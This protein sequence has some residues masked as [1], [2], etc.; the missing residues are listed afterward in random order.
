MTAPP[1]P[2]PL[3]LPS[4]F[5]RFRPGFFVTSPLGHAAARRAF[6]TTRGGWKIS[7]LRLFRSPSSMRVNL[8]HPSLSNTHC[9]CSERNWIIDQQRAGHNTRHAL[10][11]ACFPLSCPPPFLLPLSF[12]PPPCFID[13][14]L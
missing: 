14:D 5:T 1:L 8:G 10:A 12:L 6:T 4:P 2:R 13:S 7:R 3:P 11:N 9:I